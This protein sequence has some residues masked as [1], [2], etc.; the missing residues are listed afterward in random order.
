MN[1]A[2][3]T[4]L[5][6]RSYA[7]RSTAGSETGGVHVPLSQ[8]MAHGQFKVSEPSQPSSAD[9]RPQE[10]APNRKCRQTWMLVHVAQPEVGKAWPLQEEVAQQIERTLRERSYSVTACSPLGPSRSLYIGGLFAPTYSSCIS[11][12]PML[13]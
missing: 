11:T 3:F 7:S 6:Y 10:H 1:Y 4:P 2:I 12:R 13:S 8:R 5:C 9:C